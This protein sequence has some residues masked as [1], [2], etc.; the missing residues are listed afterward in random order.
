MSRLHKMSIQGIR[1][2]APRDE[3]IQVISFFSPLT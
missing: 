1:S 2:F 3:D